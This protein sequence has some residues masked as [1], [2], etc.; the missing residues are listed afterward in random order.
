MTSSSGAAS[1]VFV[2]DLNNDEVDVLSASFGDD[3]IVWYKNEGDGNFASEQNISINAEADGAVSVYAADL[4]G[5]GD[6]D[7][8]SASSFVN[9]IAWYENLRPSCRYEDSLN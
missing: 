2:S 9:K 7:V 8:L 4:D 6:M 1:S 3:K 5:D